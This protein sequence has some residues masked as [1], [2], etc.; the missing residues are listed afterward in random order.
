MFP[1]NSTSLLTRV[2]ELRFC[3]EE[4]HRRQ[5]TDRRRAW[6]WQLKEKAARQVLAMLNSK[7]GGESSELTATEQ[8]QLIT[9][10]ALLQFPHVVATSGAPAWRRELQT[11]ARLTL[12]QNFEQIR[13]RCELPPSA[14]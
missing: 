5:Q 4:L 7:T 14:L 12:R 3:L 8:N 11:R 13:Q 1:L 2:A 10:H 6:L 9:D